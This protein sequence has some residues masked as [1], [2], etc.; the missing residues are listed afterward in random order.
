LVYEQLSQR[1]S[2]TDDVLVDFRRKEDGR[3]EDGRKDETATK[4]EPWAWST[5]REDVSAEDVTA[6]LED[7]KRKAASEED[8]TAK[9]AKVTGVKSQWE[10]GLSG[11]EKGMLAGVSDETTEGRRRAE[12]RAADREKRRLQLHAKL[13]HHAAARRDQEPPSS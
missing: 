9:K 7:A 8:R 12:A 2:A 4:A 6:L 11:V 5:G 3:K 10:R 13:R 1:R